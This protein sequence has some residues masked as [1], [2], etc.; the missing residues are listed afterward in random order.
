[1]TLAEPQR[2]IDHPFLV[3]QHDGPDDAPDTYRRQKQTATTRRLTL[4]TWE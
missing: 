1:M 3:G 2:V 4:N